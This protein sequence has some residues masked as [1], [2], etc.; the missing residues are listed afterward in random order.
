MAQN[1]GKA[2]EAKLKEDFLKVDGA[3]IDRLYDKFIRF[4]NL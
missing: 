2:F 1:Y 4:C 3:T